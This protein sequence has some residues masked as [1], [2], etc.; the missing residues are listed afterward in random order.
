MVAKGSIYVSF[1][2][3]YVQGAEIFPTT[4]R[5]T[6]I[7]D[8]AIRGGIDARNWQTTSLLLNSLCSHH[9]MKPLGYT[10]CINEQTL[11]NVEM[12]SI[13]IAIST[14]YIRQIFLLPRIDFDRQ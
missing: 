2:G 9:V 11:P 12:F 13:T 14:L 1:I 5:Y 4:V 3:I 7:S 10:F 6:S 8:H